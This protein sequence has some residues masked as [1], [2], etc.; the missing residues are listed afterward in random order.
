MNDENLHTEELTR[1]DDKKAIEIHNGT[2]SNIDAVALVMVKSGI[3]ADVRSQ[4]QAIVKI[5]AGRELGLSPI[6][7]MQMLYIVGSQ[8]GARA[9]LIASKIKASKKYDYIVDELTNEKCSISFYEKA[10]KERTKIGTVEFTMEDAR[11]IV[12]SKTGKPITA[13]D[14]WKN[15]PRN[16]LFARTI[17]NGMRWFCPDALSSIISISAEELNDISIAPDRVVFES[18]P[19]QTEIKP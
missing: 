7:S 9:I 2:V 11:K 8:I 15:Y 13:K 18:Q 4:Y 14:N 10:E 17:M 5:M 12:D 19:E 6:E 16:M 3:F 1:K